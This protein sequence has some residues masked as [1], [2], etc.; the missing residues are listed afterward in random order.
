MSCHSVAP[1]QDAVVSSGGTDACMESPNCDG[2]LGVTTESV[3]VGS[4][5]SIIDSQVDIESC[6]QIQGSAVEVLLG[7]VDANS[8]DTSDDTFDDAMSCIGYDIPCQ[9]STDDFEDVLDGSQD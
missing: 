8:M 7:D 3:D 2:D 6:G 5:S 4:C 9:L 1:V